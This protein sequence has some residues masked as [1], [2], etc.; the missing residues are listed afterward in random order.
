MRESGFWGQVF[1]SQHEKPGCVVRRC[2]TKTVCVGDSVVLEVVADEV[3]VA[4]NDQ[5]LLLS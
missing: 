3:N 2:R 1:D 5:P 4:A